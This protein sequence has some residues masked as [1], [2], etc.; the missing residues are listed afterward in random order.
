MSETRCYVL[1]TKRKTILAINQCAKL[2]AYT[3]LVAPQPKQYDTN[4]SIYKFMLAFGAQP[5]EFELEP[6]IMFCKL[7]PNIMFCQ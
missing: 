6:N 1:N 5:Q 3:N 4:Y 2:F 7:E